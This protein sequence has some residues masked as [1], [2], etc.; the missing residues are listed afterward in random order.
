[1][2][3]TYPIPASDAASCGDVYI[4]IYVYLYIC[5]YIYIYNMCVLKLIVVRVGGNSY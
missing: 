3:H 2:G 1:M 4:C 5:I